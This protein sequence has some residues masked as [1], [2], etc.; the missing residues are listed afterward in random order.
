MASRTAFATVDSNLLP[1]D[2]D[3]SLLPASESGKAGGLVA[4]QGPIETGMEARDLHKQGSRGSES[5]SGRIEEDTPRPQQ[6]SSSADMPAAANASTTPDAPPP[7]Q[8]STVAG[9]RMT[10]CAAP[11]DQLGTAN[12]H[13]LQGATAPQSAHQAFPMMSDKRSAS[14][15]YLARQSMR[16]GADAMT[17]A[18]ARAEETVSTSRAHHREANL[19]LSVP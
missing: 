6:P 16:G 1:T 19:V 14:D 2:T 4:R 15:Q 13:R 10:T 18:T 5:N 9:E 3:L 17:H 11:D 7:I 8:Q 12:G